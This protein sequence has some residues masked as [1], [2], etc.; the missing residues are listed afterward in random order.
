[1]LILSLCA[2]RRGER[3]PPPYF[4]LLKALGVTTFAAVSILWVGMRSAARHML[5]AYGYAD[6]DTHAREDRPNP[7]H[8]DTQNKAAAML[9]L[10][11]L[12]VLRRVAD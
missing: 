9:L 12:L 8:W 4:L 11:L 10:L 7:R 2:G 6:L 5:R 3:I 1:M